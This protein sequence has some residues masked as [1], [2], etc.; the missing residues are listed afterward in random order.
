M[1]KNLP[2]VLFTAF[3]ALTGISL[4]AQ[5]FRVSYKAAGVE[6]FSGR[7]LLYLSQDN[8]QPKDGLVTLE[9]FPV[10]V[11]N[12]RN[13]KAGQ[14]LV[15]D[16]AATSY[17][18]P[19]SSIERGYYYVQAVWD[20]NLGGRAIAESPGN[21]I[22]APVRLK[23]ARNIDSTYVLVCDSI[24]P[25]RSFQ[26]TKYV[27]E[28]RLPSPLLTAFHHKPMTIDVAVILPKEYDSQKGRRFPV[29]YNASG[30]GGDYHSYSGKNVPSAAID[31]TPC[32]RVFLDG[33]CSLGHMVYANSDNNGP[34]GDALITELIPYIDR[35]YRTDNARFLYGH[36][37]GGWTVLWLQSQY[38]SVFTACWSSSPDP[39]DFRSFQRVDLYHDRNMFYDKDSVLRL[40]ATVAGRYPW[41]TMK[42]AYGMERV[43]YRGE[44]M[45][46][47]DAV[48]GARMMDNEPRRLVDAG[49]GVIDTETVEHWKRYDISLNLRTHWDTL[50]PLLDGKIR[51][52]VGSRDN[53]LLNYAVNL[54]EAEMQK[55]GA[56]MIFVYYPGDHFTVNTPEYWKTGYQFLESKYKPGKI[57]K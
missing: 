44:Q 43:V 5:K 36:S 7:V 22:S 35:Q 33:N 2:L 38:P 57:P 1:K 4:H 26:E 14:N 17:P 25:A 29:L 56:D 32:I 23:I 10:S 30:Y 15:L 8:R 52:T 53:F 49:T 54:L 51:V 19:L 13:I 34:W 55:L 41:A 28:V 21:I 37:S 47:F 45:H 9:R 42:Q 50:K 3:F 48:F 39:V 18:A 16:D 31:T 46:S 40:V 6:T 11:I 24:L 12:I 20:R 27:K